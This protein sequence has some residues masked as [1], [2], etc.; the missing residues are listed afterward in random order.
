MKCHLR[1][2]VGETKLTFEEHSTVLTQVQACLNSQP[3]GPVPDPDDG[4]DAL[5]PGHFLIGRPLEALPDSSLVYQPNSL[6]R[7]WQLC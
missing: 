1:K 6:L 3:L 7:R 4:I 5:M 2:I